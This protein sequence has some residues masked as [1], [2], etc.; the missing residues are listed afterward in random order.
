MK[1]RVEFWLESVFE[2]CHRCFNSTSNDITMKA[3][4]YECNLQHT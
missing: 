4:L 2:T 1:T 3:S